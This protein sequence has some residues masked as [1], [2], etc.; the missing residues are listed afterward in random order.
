LRW[1]AMRS[2]QVGD[3]V[4]G[5]YVLRREIARGGGGVVYEAV[6]RFTTR[7]VAIKLLLDEHQLHPRTG[8]RLLR[9]A[10]ALTVARHRNVVSVLDAGTT[11][12]GGPYL[13]MELLEGRAL[14]G[15]LAA[16]RTLS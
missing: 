12:D 4:D 1:R 3:Q 14:D 15:I 13:V 10:R 7:S 11:K 9:E 16:R 5:R 2:F 6:Q 8:M